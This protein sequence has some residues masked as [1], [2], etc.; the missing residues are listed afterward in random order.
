MWDEI[1]LSGEKKYDKK[2]YFV[3]VKIHLSYNLKAKELIFRADNLFPGLNIT[4][5]TFYYK[6]KLKATNY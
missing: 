6:M 2:I 5:N 1:W 4:L 3:Y